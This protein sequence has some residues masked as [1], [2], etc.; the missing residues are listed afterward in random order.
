MSSDDFL[1]LITKMAMRENLARVFQEA[2]TEHKS[3]PLPGLV[4]L[5]QKVEV[6]VEELVL[7][8][9]EIVKRGFAQRIVRVVSPLGGGI[10]D[11]KSIDEVPTQIY[12]ERQGR[13]IDVQP[14]NL[15]IVY[16]F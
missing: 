15:L 14:E 1:S 11:F 6:P 10:R 12:D 16:K 2:K 7:A 9:A 5:A 8:L 3:L 13:E 4:A